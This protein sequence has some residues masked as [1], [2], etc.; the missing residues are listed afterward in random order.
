MVKNMQKPELS[1]AAYL[2]H[3]ALPGQWRSAGAGTGS[4]L[5]FC[6]S[7]GQGLGPAGTQPSH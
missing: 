4:S 3:C 5:P 2:S 7:L 1:P 6:M